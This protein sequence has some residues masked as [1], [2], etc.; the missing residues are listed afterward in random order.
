MRGKSLRI[1]K[2][3]RWPGRVIK[4]LIASEINPGK[5]G[6]WNKMSW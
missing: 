5:A 4:P 1:E 2:G 3:M 6:D